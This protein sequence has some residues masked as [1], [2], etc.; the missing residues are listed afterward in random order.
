MALF[1]DFKGIVQLWDCSKQ[2]QQQQQWGAA[3]SDCAGETMAAERALSGSS[4]CS[5]RQNG[6]TTGTYLQDTRSY[7]M[8][9]SLCPGTSHT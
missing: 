7:L 9:M 3:G 5:L 8:V 2:Q 1:V 4:C 6:S